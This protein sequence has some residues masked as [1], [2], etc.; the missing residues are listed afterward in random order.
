M[1]NHGSDA[2]ANLPGQ[3]QVGLNMLTEHKARL[4]GHHNKLWGMSTMLFE[5][6]L[7]FG[8]EIFQALAPT[9]R[10]GWWS[11]LN[12]LTL[13]GMSKQPALLSSALA[14]SIKTKTNQLMITK[15]KS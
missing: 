6:Q 2:R 9:T 8:M 15:P 7:Y 11:V 13:T 12:S 4:D 10:T 5:D 1:L 3:I 14:T